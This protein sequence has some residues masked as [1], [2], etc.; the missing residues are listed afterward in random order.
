MEE[1]KEIKKPNQKLE[2]PYPLDKV[3]YERVKRVDVKDWS[4]YFSNEKIAS[5]K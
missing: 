1:E 5:S 4:F 3:S 2:I